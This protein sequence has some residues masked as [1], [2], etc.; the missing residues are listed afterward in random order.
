M[1]FKTMIKCPHCDFLQ[2][3]RV[4]IPKG[5]GVIHCDSC[6]MDYIH[7]WSLDIVSNTRKIEGEELP[8][9]TEEI[10]QAAHIGE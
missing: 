5:H 10:K 6:E 7:D 9:N 3:R 8:E 1:E 4:T 2:A